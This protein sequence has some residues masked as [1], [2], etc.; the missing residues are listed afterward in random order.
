M[1]EAV[2]VEQVHERLGWA[3]PLRPA[4]ASAG[5]AL[6]DW[7]MEI[8]D[9]PIFRQIYRQARPSR[10][11]EFGTWEGTGVTYCLEECA[12]TVWTINLLHGESDAQG[13]WSYYQSQ[14]P[15]APVPP[16]PPE[17]PEPAWTNT[18]VSPKGN[19][20]V[21]TDALGFI[22][23]HYLARNLGHR[24]CQIYGDSR[25]WDTSNYPA[26]FF[27]TVLIDGGHDREVVCNDTHKALP[28]VRS[29]GIILWHDFCPCTEV[30][31]RCVSPR[32]V[33]DAIYEM[34][35]HLRTELRDLFW[36]QPSWILLGVK[37]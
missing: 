7:K 15:D 12:A 6:H 18:R 3:Q 22:G 9:A 16:E 10:H 35:A 4:P 27:D 36:I 1:I 25:K 32:G 24:V 31:A 20:L 19:T 5:K 29:G 11:L 2:P 17:P 28:L 34:Q 37:R 14:T 33:L 13:H 26:G 30:L 23:R 8:D 21:Q